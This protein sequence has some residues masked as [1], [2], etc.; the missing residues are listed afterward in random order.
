MPLLALRAGKER[1]LFIVAMVPGGRLIAAD[2][3]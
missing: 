3:Y 1:I 2:P